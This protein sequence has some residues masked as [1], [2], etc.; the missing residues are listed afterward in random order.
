MSSYNSYTIGE[1]EAHLNG[2]LEAADMC[3]Q[4]LRHDVA[5]V[6]RMAVTVRRASGIGPE[7]SAKTVQVDDWA[8]RYI[9]AVRKQAGNRIASKA[10]GIGP[11]ASR[12][13]AEVPH[14]SEEYIRSHELL[15][16]GRMAFRVKSVLRSF[17]T[18]HDFLNA[19][20]AQILSAPGCGPTGFVILKRLR[21]ELLG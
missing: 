16:D 2:M 10:S 14:W 4:H 12:K 11:E 18:K 7:A 5:N 13:P 19:S 8:K 6:I 3:D 9:D 1:A 21:D 20:E 15:K 17:R